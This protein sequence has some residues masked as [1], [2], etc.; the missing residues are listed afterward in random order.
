MRCSPATRF[1][2]LPHALPSIPR[3]SSPLQ[4][5]PGSRSPQSTIRGRSRSWGKA[6]GPTPPSATMLRGQGE[7]RDCVGRTTL[8]ISFSIRG[9]RSTTA[10]RSSP[11]PSGRTAG[12]AVVVWGGPQFSERD[13]GRGSRQAQI[14]TWTRRSSSLPLGAGQ[15]RDQQRG[16]GGLRR[17]QDQRRFSGIF[18]NDIEG[19]LAQIV[20]AR[21]PV[22]GLRRCGRPG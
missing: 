22:P 18:T 14:P 3:R 13:S 8:S 7:L 6:P 20:G 19:N 9:R 11:W 5:R 2:Q 15:A 1:R 10:A 17:R 12:N 16:H 21:Q 4:L